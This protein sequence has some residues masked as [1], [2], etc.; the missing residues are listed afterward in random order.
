V[1]V[2]RLL[3]VVAV[4]L[5]VTAFAVAA[6]SDRG[7]GDAGG[8]TTAAAPSPSPAA[9]AGEPSPA[10]RDAAAPGESIRTL[11][12]EDAGQI[13]RVAAGERIRVRVVSDELETVQLG[14]DG[15]IEVVDP[16]SPA[17]FEILAEDGLDADVRLLESGR[18]IGRVTTGG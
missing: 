18:T 14:E 1:L 9:G 4:L 13:V 10:E 11:R 17:E 2:R 15:P 12:A 8:G 5:A 6:D 7:G 16:E 3:I